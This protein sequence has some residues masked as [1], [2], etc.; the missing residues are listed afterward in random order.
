MRDLHP[1]RSARLCL[2]TTPA[3][4][5]DA[6]APVAAGEWP[7]RRLKE[8]KVGPFRGFRREEQFD[9]RKRVILFYGPNGSGKTSLCEALER[10]LLGSVEETELKRIDERRYLANIHVG[11]FVEPRLIATTADGNDVQVTAVCSACTV[12]SPVLLWVS[13][14][15]IS[16]CDRADERRPG[17]LS[18]LAVLRP[19]DLSIPIKLRIKSFRVP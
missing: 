6:D 17:T 11:R 4:V 15:S 18:R 14:H 19:C 3:A 5:P 1:S 8:L 9:L 7:W 13:E 2:A 10:G 12:V 16:Y